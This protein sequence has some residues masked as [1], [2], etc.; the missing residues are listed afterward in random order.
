MCLGRYDGE[1][2]TALKAEKAKKDAA[3][4]KTEQ[5][6]RDLEEKLAKATINFEKAAI[7]SKKKMTRL[8]D[9]NEKARQKEQ[10][11]MMLLWHMN[12]YNITLWVYFIRKRRK[13]F[14]RRT[15]SSR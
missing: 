13:S 14:P 11:R 7:E 8:E 15:R 3:A 9:E 4:T 10:V 12:L 5:E 1:K 6:R 2:R